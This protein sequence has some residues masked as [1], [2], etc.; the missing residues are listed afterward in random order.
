MGHPIDDRYKLAPDPKSQIAEI[1]RQRKP[2]GGRNLA[3]NRE[4]VS[5]VL[6]GEL[7]I[8]L[9]L[10]PHDTH[11]NARPSRWAKAKAVKAQRV[12]AELTAMA[13]GVPRL[14]LTSATVQASFWFG[15]VRNR[16]EDNAAAWL[17][18]TWDGLTSYG[19]FRDD[20]GLHHLPVAIFVDGSS[21]RLEIRVSAT[22]KGIE[23]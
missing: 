17:K 9:P 22:T 23:A 20:R 8:V 15:S 10:P 4:R 14:H 7:V 6:T 12:D 3:T 1:M 11:P 18:A 2:L 16:D 13:L 5:G 21:P 19:L